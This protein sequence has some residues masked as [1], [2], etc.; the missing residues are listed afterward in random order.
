M[1]KINLVEDKTMTNSK[2]KTEVKRSVMEVIVSALIAE[3]GEENVS[4]CRTG[5]GQSKTNEYMV[6]VGEVTYGD[7]V[8]ELC[9]TVNA[10]AKDYRERTGNKGQ[11]YS[12][13][14][15]NVLREEYSIYLDEKNSKAA[16]AADKKAKKIAKDSAARAKKN[17]S[18][19]DGGGL[20]DF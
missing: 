10:S 15:F 4:P 11:V 6:R 18:D 2:V 12:P 1:A 7:E 14:N 16:D 5:N 8:F 3:Y 13:F 9:A 19:E 20:M 17:G